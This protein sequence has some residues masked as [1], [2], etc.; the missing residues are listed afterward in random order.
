VENEET[1]SKFEST[2][3]FVKA[4]KTAFAVGTTV[5]VGTILWRSS[6]STF[7]KFL[8]LHGLEEEFEDFLMNAEF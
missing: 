3:N 8:E 2:I 6:L 5:V 1:T 7:D 4:H